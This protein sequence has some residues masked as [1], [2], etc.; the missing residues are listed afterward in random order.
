VIH[1]DTALGEDVLQIT[2]RQS[3]PQVPADRQQD[4]IRR[5]RNP[6]NAEGAGTGGLARRL[7]L[8]A[9][10]LPQD[11]DPSKQQSP[12]HSSASPAARPTSSTPW[13]E[14][15]ATSPPPNPKPLDN[16]IGTPP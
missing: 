13:S 1:V 5:N 15:T 14:T 11:G 8:I 3:V 6:A 16:E 2:V 7:H 10:A 4:H 9:S 12:P